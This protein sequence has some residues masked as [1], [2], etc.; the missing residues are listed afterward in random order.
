VDR[1]VSRL[2]VDFLEGDIGDDVADLELVIERVAHPGPH[3]WGFG[4]DSCHVTVDA[5][6]ALV[7]NDVTGEQMTLP[8]TDFLTILHDYARTLRDDTGTHYLDRHGDTR[9]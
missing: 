7:E 2:L 8:R 1:T 5:D 6:E 3:P 4:G 9:A